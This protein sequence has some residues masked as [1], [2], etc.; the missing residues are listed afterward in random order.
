MVGVFAALDAMLFYVFLGGDADPDVHHHRCL[1]RTE[2]CLRDDKV[3]YTFLGSVFMLVAL[4]Y[5]Y[6]KSGSVRWRSR[7]STI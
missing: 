4:I 5:M 1:G 6:F 2:P 3:L 7:R